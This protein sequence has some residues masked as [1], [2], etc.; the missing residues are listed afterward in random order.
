MADIDLVIT[1]LKDIYP[2]GRTPAD[3]LDALGDLNKINDIIHKELFRTTEHPD[4]ILV[5]LDLKFNFPEYYEHLTTDEAQGKKLKETLRNLIIRYCKILA[6]SQEPDMPIH[7]RTV[8]GLEH[9][10]PRLHS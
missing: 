10:N 9:Y 8:A 3:Y 2:Y 5:V 4:Y 1:L 6:D 7:I